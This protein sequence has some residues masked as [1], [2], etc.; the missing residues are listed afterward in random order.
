METDLLAWVVWFYHSMK[1][2]LL[3]LLNCVCVNNVLDR[4][5]CEDP[6]SK[7]VSSGSH[8]A[9]D[10]RFRFFKK[11]DDVLRPSF[12]RSSSSCQ[13]ISFNSFL[14]STNQTTTT[15]THTR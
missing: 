4:F 12:F 3:C 8:W 2:L 6:D 9:T 5:L 14:T 11:E 1:C 10:R 15:T 7:S 13:Q